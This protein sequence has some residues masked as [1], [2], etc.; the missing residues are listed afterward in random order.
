MKPKKT[1]VAVG[2]STP[3]EAFLSSNHVTDARVCT[4]CRF[5]I[6]DVMSILQLCYTQP[7]S[8]SGGY[9]THTVTYVKATCNA[10]MYIAKKQRVCA[11]SDTLISRGS[12]RG[13][14]VIRRQWHVAARMKHVNKLV[15]NRRGQEGNSHHIRQ[16]KKNGRKDKPKTG[17]QNQHRSVLRTLKIKK[18]TID[19]VRNV[20]SPKMRAFL[21]FA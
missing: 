16:E 15:R 21:I 1:L 2:V 8:S 6:W 17:T 10:R 12:L 18:E 19:N 9:N 13:E 7:L 3:P 11:M 5:E 14:R 20:I 4:A